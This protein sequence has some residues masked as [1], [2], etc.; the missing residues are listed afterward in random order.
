MVYIGFLVAV[1]FFEKCSNIFKKSGSFR[2]SKCTENGYR[3][4][5]LSQLSFVCI[6]VLLRAVGILPENMIQAGSMITLLSLLVVTISLVILFIYKLIQV[7]RNL[8]EREYNKETE[9]LM[10][11]ITKVTILCSI[12][13]FITL[14]NLFLMGI[15]V[16]SRSMIIGKFC[17]YTGTMDL[18]TNFICVLFCEKV[19]KDKYLMICSCLDTKCK[20]F[21]RSK[22]SLESF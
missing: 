8:N 6:I 7:Y 1:I 20:D 14:V 18:Y 21:C 15:W 12:S 10:E 22:V 4:T 13:L 17:N 2:L 16:L 11:P 19:F 5:F 9:F 3:I